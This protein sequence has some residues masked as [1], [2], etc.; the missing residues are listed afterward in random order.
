MVILSIEFVM[1]LLDYSIFLSSQIAKM[2]FILCLY[3]IMKK[4]I[5]VFQREA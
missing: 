4:I 3:F 5:L 1:Q 2:I